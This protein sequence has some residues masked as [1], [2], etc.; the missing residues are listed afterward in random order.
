MYK[1]QAPMI[2]IEEHEVYERPIGNLTAAK[3][4]KLIRALRSG[5]EIEDVLNG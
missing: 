3:S 5:S 4:I 2:W 1:R